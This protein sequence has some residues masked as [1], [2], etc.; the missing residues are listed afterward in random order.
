MR[1][2]HIEIFHAVYVTGSITS[3][4]KVLCV[5][6]PSV[7]KVLAHAEMQLG[8]Q[9]FKRAKGKLTPTSEAHMLFSEIDNIYKQLSSIKKMAENIKK[10]EKGLVDI[11]ITPAL[12]FELIP[13]VI[14]EFHKI[15]PNVEFKVKTL[16]NQEAMQALIE[17]RCDLA[18][19]FSS[20]KMPGVSEVELG[21]SEMVAMYPKEEFPHSPE[22]ITFSELAE[23]DLIGIWESGPLGELLWNRFSEL[24]V[25]V[26]DH[27]QVDTYFIAARLV[28]YGVGCCMIDSLTAAANKKEN[29]GTAS[30]S[31]KA[32][33]SVK[34]LYLESQ[35]LPKICEDFIELVKKE[36]NR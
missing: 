14:S 27:V 32:S 18:L 8:F 26:N 25:D 7:S 11:A 12:G 29:I 13:K 33:I 6:Q 30:L 31:P 28:G 20:P 24:G 15:H 17:H 10:S 21:Q 2:R 23:K 1:L 9:L 22:E 36:L 16:H 4:A 3:A 19:L 35:P 5:S 34:G